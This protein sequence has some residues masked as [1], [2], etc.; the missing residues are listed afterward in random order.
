MKNKI[1]KQ[2]EI[3]LDP[4]DVGDTRIVE[5][6]AFLPKIVC[7]RIVFLQKYY[8]K[9]ILTNPWINDHIGTNGRILHW[10]TKEL[11]LTR[12]D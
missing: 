12:Q 11:K 4:H 7:T 8:V 1:I 2:H 5:K 10:I 3:L 9:Q 6:F